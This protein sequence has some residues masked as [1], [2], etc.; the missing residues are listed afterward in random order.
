MR[1]IRKLKRL[2]IQTLKKRILHPEELKELERLDA[3]PEVEGVIGNVHPIDM[4]MSED[5]YT[6][7]V[8]IHFNR[9]I[10]WIALDFNDTKA[11]SEKLVARI[12]RVERERP[13]P[14]LRPKSVHFH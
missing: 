7:G 2:L 4:V 9:K 12:A 10:D 5:P 11:L 1:I 13:T 14:N 8:V 3:N 6:L